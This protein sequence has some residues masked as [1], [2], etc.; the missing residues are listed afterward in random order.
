MGRLCRT[1]RTAQSGLL[2]V[3]STLR[4]SYRISAI[5]SQR[6]I[7][8]V[9]SSSSGQIELLL[10]RREC[11]LLPNTTLDLTFDTLHAPIN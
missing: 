3:N 8:P 9:E 2:P 11:L 7:F 6:I 4:C 5:R 10:N 1:I